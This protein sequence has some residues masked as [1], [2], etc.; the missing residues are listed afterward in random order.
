M[1]RGM[2]AFV[3]CVALTV[4]ARAALV[5]IPPVQPAAAAGAMILVTTTFGQDGTRYI[6]EI[7]GER[8]NALPQWEPRL[9]PEPPLSMSAARKAAESW[10]TSRIPEIKT[11]EV[12]SLFFAKVFQGLPTGPCRTVSCWY[13][14]ITF[15][16]V[17][18]G[19]RLAGG[20]DFAAVVLIDGSIVEPRIENA[21]V[22]PSGAGRGGGGS[23]GPGSRTGGGGGP[24]TVPVP[25]PDAGGVYIADPGN[26]V[27]APRVVQQA[28]PQ[29]TRAAMSA[30]IQGTVWLE[31]V[32]NTDGKV[33]EVKVIKSLDSVY[34]LDDEAIKAVKQFRFAPG[35]RDGA[36]VPVRV[37]IEMDFSLQ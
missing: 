6:Y 28:K 4:S 2:A 16:P 33:G 8:A 14:R 23:G 32:V 29:Y 11:F 22:A 17:V 31:A 19:R 35:T 34:G 18:G 1:Q 26:G 37:Q 30:K 12:S 7:P 24:R 13:Y 5:Q 3:F 36:P 20:S 9:A 21:P 25:S 27:I 10:L 15:D